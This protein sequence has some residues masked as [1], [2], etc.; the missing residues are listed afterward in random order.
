MT[1][2][3]SFLNAVIP[4]VIAVVGAYILYRPLKDPLD[5]LF[6]GIGRFFGAIKRMISGEDQEE[7]LLE[8]LEYE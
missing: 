1:D 4:W 3:D 8:T 5:P 7:I 2:F 6:R